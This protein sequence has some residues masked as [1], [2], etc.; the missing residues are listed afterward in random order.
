[1][2]AEYFS[3]FMGFEI[4]GYTPSTGQRKTKP[5]V[6]KISVNS[7]SIENCQELFKDEKINDQTHMCGYAVEG[8]QNAD[9]VINSIIYFINSR[10]GS[11]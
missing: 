6:S 3:S 5:M 11:I 10:I 7:T 9:F 2:S 8:N 1:M 4:I